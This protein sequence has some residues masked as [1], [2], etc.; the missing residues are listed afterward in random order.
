MD[1]KENSKKLVKRTTKIFK[2]K[3]QTNNNDQKSNF[4]QNNTLENINIPKKISFKK[5]PKKSIIPIRAS[6][7]SFGP[8]EKFKQTSKP[9][10]CKIPSKNEFN[11]FPVMSNNKF[12]NVK[13]KI[14]NEIK[15][16]MT[17]DLTLK[18]IEIQKESSV[19]PD[20][21]ET[22][23]NENYIPMEDNGKD[24][25]NKEKTKKKNEVNFSQM[26]NL[27]KKKLFLLGK[28]ER[29][30]S[31]IFIE[32]IEVGTNSPSFQKE[33][34]TK[35]FISKAQLLSPNP[36]SNKPNLVYKKNNSYHSI[37]FYESI[38][39]NNNNKSS[40]LNKYL[41]NSS[42]SKNKETIKLNNKIIKN[43]E[44]LFNL[45]NR[46][47]RNDYSNRKSQNIY[48]TNSSIKL[49]KLEKEKKSIKNPIPVKSLKTSKFHKKNEKATKK[50]DSKNKMKVKKIPKIININLDLDS[51]NNPINY[52]S[53]S[54]NVLTLGEISSKNTEN[55]I[56]KSVL[57]NEIFPTSTLQ[58][59]NNHNNQVKSVISDYI[60]N[61]N[62]TTEDEG[63]KK[64]K[65]KFHERNKFSQ[66]TINES[67]E[68]YYDV[69]EKAFNNN[70]IEQ[71]FSF[72]PR[73]KK[74][75]IY[76]SLN[77]FVPE[78]N[79]GLIKIKSISSF[80]QNND[81]NNTLN[82]LNDKSIKKKSMNQSFDEN[83]F[84]DDNKDDALML[85]N[86]NFILDLNH[87]IPI[88]KTKLMNTMAKPLY[89]T[90]NRKKNK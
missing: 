13:R 21:N 61:Y 35:E 66:K 2:T 68:Q 6:K 24:K 19:M 88:D 75:D 41:K 46:T 15:N 86:K 64:K 57:N 34:Q 11:I 45:I 79:N 29:Q 33:S 31:V 30:N 43:R 67:S 25:N 47:T 1:K 78:D 89:I 16:K 49:N 56:S 85:D 12:G 23:P 9:K 80:N 73:S 76:R 70:C 82:E 69:Y 39:D 74:K 58:M 26:L 20:K 77:F 7:K 54:S 17:K 18:S 48:N 10:F 87:F 4:A 55:P 60:D 38:F 3:N 72:K 32:P 8:L 84:S 52:I 28:E 63:E 81:I 90:N 36:K 65:Y 37:N 27:K 14:S 50:D 22:V 71:K 40:E 5:S 59:S 42:K 62:L 51:F 83:M 44:I 53:N